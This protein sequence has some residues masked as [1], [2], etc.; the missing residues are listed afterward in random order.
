MRLDVILRDC[1]RNE[2]Q[3]IAEHRHRNRQ[4]NQIAITPETHLDAVVQH[5]GR[6]HLLDGTAD[7]AV[8]YDDKAMGTSLVVVEA[9]SLDTF[10]EG[11]SQCLAYLGKLPV[12][13]DL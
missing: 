3:W 10:G 2:R 1:V 7:Y 11:L 13:Q 8:W 5:K 12:L 6:D 4:E 9:K